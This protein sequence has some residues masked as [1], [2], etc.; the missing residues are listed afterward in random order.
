LTVD[1]SN[2][3]F[4][5]EVTGLMGS[6]FTGVGPEHNGGNPTH[7]KPQGFDPLGIGGTVEFCFVVAL[8]D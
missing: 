7:N 2:H 6:G 8:M 5:A 4:L 1:R 3:R